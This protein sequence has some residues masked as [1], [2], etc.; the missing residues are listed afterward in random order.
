MK[1][2]NKKAAKAAAEMKSREGDLFSTTSSTVYGFEPTKEGVTAVPYDA[3][4]LS[5][6]VAR[7]TTAEEE[8]AGGEGP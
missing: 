3:Q 1:V 7:L 6:A 2:L 5:A 4:Q 8:A